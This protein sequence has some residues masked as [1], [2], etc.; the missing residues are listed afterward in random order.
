LIVWLCV[1]TLNGGVNPNNH[2]NGIRHFCRAANDIAMS[3]L[4]HL[5]SVKHTSIIEAH[6]NTTGFDLNPWLA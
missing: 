6:V 3:V 4:R 5:L 2:I 1:S